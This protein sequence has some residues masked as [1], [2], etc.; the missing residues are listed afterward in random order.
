MK[1][2]VLDDTSAASITLEEGN[3]IY[4]ERATGVMQLVKTDDLS[5]EAL[6][7]AVFTLYQGDK[8]LGDF[9]TGNSYAKDASGNWNAESGRRQSEDFWIVMG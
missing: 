3:T 9:T 5:K 7:G 8:K 4:N 6:N 2:F 1:E